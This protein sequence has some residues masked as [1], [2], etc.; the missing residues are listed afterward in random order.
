MR[1]KGDIGQYLSGMPIKVAGCNIAVSQPS[2]KEICAYGENDFL[3]G[4]QIFVNIKK[5]ISPIKVGNSQLERFDDFQVLLASLDTQVDVKDKIVGL[6]DLIFPKYQY[7]FDAGCIN[8]RVDDKSP[9]IGQINPMNFDNFQLVLKEL[10]LPTTQEKEEE[11]FNPV[12]DQAAEIAAKLKKG[13]EQRA[14]LKAEEKG[15]EEN[16]S[17]FG[18]YISALG[19]GLSIDVNILYNYTPFQ[20]YDAI[21]RFTAKAASDLYQKV[22]TTPLM[23]VSKMDEPKSWLENIY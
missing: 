8:F 19:V 20:L 16:I 14:A 3:F 22:A 12:N 5:I 9:I 6:F 1:L 11:D 18:N 4:V 15:S 10:F 7:E 13:R 23:D 21:L 2:I 17:M